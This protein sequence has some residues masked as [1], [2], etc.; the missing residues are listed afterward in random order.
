MKETASNSNEHMIEDDKAGMKGGLVLP[1]LEDGTDNSTGGISKSETSR[2]RAE[3]LSD[4]TKNSKP[5][6]THSRTSKTATPVTSTFPTTLETTLPTNGPPKRD[7]SSRLDPLSKYANAKRSHKKGAGA[8]A[9]ML[10]A[11]VADKGS[12]AVHLG[13]DEGDDEEED[14]P[15]YCY[16]NSVSYGE[17]V[18]CDMDGCAREWFHLQCVGLRKPPVNGISSLDS[19]PCTC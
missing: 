19:N 10:A 17:M 7:R 3:S 16:C 12:T 8:A 14:E 6:R 9:Q 15:R 2:A 1:S 4:V 18:A 5:T 11:A 13:A